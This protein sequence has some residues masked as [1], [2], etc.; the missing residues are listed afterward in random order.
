MVKHFIN[1]VIFLSVLGF[2]FADKAFAQ[3]TSY[4]YTNQEQDESGLMYY[5]SRYY[6]PDLGR[7]L[8]PD[9]Y[10]VPNKYAYVSNDPVNKV[11]PSGHIDIPTADDFFGFH[12]IPQMSSD[13]G[14]CCDTNGTI[15]LDGMWLDT[16][17]TLDFDSFPRDLAGEYESSLIGRYLPPEIGVPI[18]GLSSE[19]WRLT[20]LQLRAMGGEYLTIGEQA[21]LVTGKIPLG[22]TVKWAKNVITAGKLDM[23]LTNKI[24]TAMKLPFVGNLERLACSQMCLGDASRVLQANKGIGALG[25]VADDI[26]VHYFPI[27]EKNGIPWVTD[28]PLYGKIMVSNHPEKKLLLK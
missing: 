13:L 7:F 22:F 20:T 3:A 2:L 21:E 10:D 25:K 9:S 6:D 1:F 5:D 24:L 17:S 4:T 12:S 19:L 18:Q 23:I 14:K 16:N 28:T 15:Y 27:L 11:D 8:Q 26:G